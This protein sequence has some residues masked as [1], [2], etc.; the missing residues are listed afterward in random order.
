[1]PKV[2]RRP[3]ACNATKVAPRRAATA[4]PWC[5]AAEAA[6][7]SAQ[8]S[9]AVRAHCVRHQGENPMTTSVKPIRLFALLLAWVPLAGVAPAFA[10][11]Y[12][13]KPV[14]WIVGYPAGGTTD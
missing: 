9:G 7:P 4:R 3:G 1:M 5:G 10:L 11:D 8:A 12:P 6:Y 14:R 2:R 13:T